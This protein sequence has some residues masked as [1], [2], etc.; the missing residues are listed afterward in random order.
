M[1]NLIIAMALQNNFAPSI[2][3]DNYLNTNHKE[4]GKSL[5]DSKD[6]TSPSTSNHPNSAT[7]AETRK[8]KQ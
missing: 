3:Q 1:S 4:N 6:E 2:K 8:T 7:K 5:R